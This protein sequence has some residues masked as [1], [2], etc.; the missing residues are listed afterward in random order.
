MYCKECGAEIDGGKFCK[1]CGTA[2]GEVKNEVRS[3]NYDPLQLDP[4]YLKWIGSLIISLAVFGILNFIFAPLA[5]VILI[6]FAVLIYVTKSINVVTVFAIIWLLLTL[7]QLYLGLYFSSTYMFLALI[8]GA[9]SI[10]ILYKVNQ[11]KK[12]TEIV[13]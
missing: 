12:V 4:K 1:E 7:Y 5:G 6:V 8:N 11:F 13:L 2:V 3:N 9:F 10:Y